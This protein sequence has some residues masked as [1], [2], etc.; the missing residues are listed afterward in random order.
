MRSY[1][2]VKR[3]KDGIKAPE[4]KGKISVLNFTKARAETITPDLI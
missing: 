1:S 4:I 3:F 2:Q